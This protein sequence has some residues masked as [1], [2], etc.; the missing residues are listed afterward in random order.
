KLIKANNLF[1]IK[2]GTRRG[3]NKLFYPEEGHGIES[4]YIKPVV[5]SSSEIDGYITNAKSEAFCCTL[6]KEKL[7]DL[8]HTG[9]LNWIRSFKNKTNNVGVPL[10]ESLDKPG[11][12]WYTMLPNTLADMVLSINPDERLF[13]AKL[14]ERSFVDQRLTRFTKKKDNTNIELTHALLNSLIGIFYIEALGFG[15]G[16]GALDLN[17]TKIK[18]N[19]FMLNPNLLNEKQK[20]EITK[21]FSLLVERDV[22]PLNKELQSKD[23]IDFD[24]AVLEAYGIKKYKKDIKNSLL[25]LYSIRKSVNN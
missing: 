22:L 10:T 13:L 15:R 4:E 12:Y 18:K 2:R 25:Q 7:A 9:A 11:I 19:L 17:T 6:S 8:G 20:G 1:E 23:R 21:K 5:R 14:K 3:W 16:L 24:N